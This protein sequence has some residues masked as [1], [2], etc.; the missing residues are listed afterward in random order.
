MAI[1]QKLW[2]GLLF[3]LWTIVTIVFALPAMLLEMAMP[4]RSDH[5][6]A[7][8]GHQVPHGPAMVLLDAVSALLTYFLAD[9]LRCWV[10]GRGWPEVVA[11]QGSTLHIHIRMAIA[12]TLA[13]PAILY[14]LGWYKPRWRSWQWR[15]RGTAAAGVL[16]GLVM[17]AVSLMLHRDLFPRSQ[18]G[19]TV[20]MIPVMTAIVLSVR[21][22]LLRTLRQSDPSVAFRDE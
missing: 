21:L 8:H 5:H 18:I 2:R 14:W 1:F 10:N 16:L 12:V 4:N 7:E 15:L 3:V 17:S 9:M 11:G 6:D 20:I 22:W 13:W 19:F